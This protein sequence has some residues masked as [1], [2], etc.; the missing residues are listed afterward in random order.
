M[1]KIYL[2]ERQKGFVSSRAVTLKIYEALNWVE[3]AAINIIHKL[4][5]EEKIAVYFRADY[6]KN[7]SKQTTFIGEARRTLLFRMRLMIQRLQAFKDNAKEFQEWR[8]AGLKGTM[9]ILIFHLEK[10]YSKEAVEKLSVWWGTFKR[11]WDAVGGVDTTEELD[12]ILTMLLNSL[13][14][15]F[16]QVRDH[17]EEKE[18]SDKENDGQERAAENRHKE[19]MG[20]LGEIKD[21]IDI[22]DKTN[23][24]ALKITEK[25]LVQKKLDEEAE[26]DEYSRYAHLSDFSEMKRYEIKK[27]IDFSHAG[28][29]IQ[30]DVRGKDVKSLKKLAAAVWND[31]KDEFERFAKLDGYSSLASFSTAL[32]NLAKKYP[33]ADHFA[34]E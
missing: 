24:K 11:L 26:E 30:R 19:V 8:F 22:N 7:F 18:K 29:S 33:A 3:D 27:A 20:A 16:S 31:N 10:A 28:F 6:P 1:S 13:D 9:D 4:E 17:I 5:Q 14:S 32:Y 21:S 15:A 2:T 34:W 25:V 12:A 23:K